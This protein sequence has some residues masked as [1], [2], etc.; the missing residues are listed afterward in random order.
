MRGMVATVSLAALVV[1]LLGSIQMGRLERGGPGH[2]D[3]ALANGV[4]GTLYLPWGEGDRAAFLDP[5]PRG[6]RPPAVVLAH[7]FSSDRMGMSSL[8]RRLAGS[9]YAV[10]AID[11]QGHGENRTPFRP[12]YATPD[13]FRPD[14]AA[15]VDY[16]RSTP[17]VDG[18]RIVV[19][20]HSM[21]AGACLDYATRDSG[22]DGAVL[23][24]GGWTLFGP[25]RPPDALFIYAEGDPDP[26]KLRV[27]ELAARVAGVEEIELGRVYGD[28]AKGTAV[29]LVEA[30]GVDHAS[31]IWSAEAATTIIEWVDASFGIERELWTVPRDPRIA[32]AGVLALALLFVLPGLGF[33]GGGGGGAGP[34][35]GPELSDAGRA[36]GL[37]MLGAALAVTLPLHSVGTPGRILSGEVADIIVTHFA[38]AG[39]V[40]MV[41]L[42]L[43]S[44]IRFG[45][46]LRGAWPALPGAAIATIGIFVLVQPLGVVT[47]RL[48]LTPERMLVFGLSVLAL[49]PF[50]L[51]FQLLLRRGATPGATL[52][53]VVGRVLVLL[54]LVIGVGVDVLP[55]VV[56][57][58]LPALAFVFIVGEVMAAALYAPSRNLVAIALVDAAWLAL[59]LVA[60][61][62]L[63][64]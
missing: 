20:G 63:R 62:P 25:Y 53:A 56:L 26:I 27:T 4:P 61:A 30:P 24:A 57:L 11:L 47:H 48:T 59:V 29:S 15:A 60:I 12:S 28:F 43:R 19:M 6:E 45:P 3:V 21:G 64:I 38:L 33:V 42:S 13:T 52:F 22:I 9:G 35:P 8:A 10:L 50:T 41:I 51:A 7:G 46:L 55:T 36:G 37:L 5:R 58:M 18:S 44:G 32:V 23:I 16:L 31:I 49:A 54:S 40:L 14:L 1:F 17:L 34:P 39:I 2:A